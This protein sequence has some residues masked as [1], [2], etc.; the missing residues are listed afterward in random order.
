MGSAIERRRAASPALLFLALLGIHSWLLA[1]SGSEVGPLRS[2]ETRAVEE[3]A[4]DFL[5]YYARVL[6]LAKRHSA[7]P[8]SL[9]AALDSLP[10]THL[11]E[12]Q[13]EAWT[14]PF[15]DDPE[16][17]ADRLEE[18]ITALSARQ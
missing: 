3:I 13:W 7:N 1:C 11:S 9:R 14:K 5:D 18:V 2:R 17:L 4:G 6:L 15:R 16:K 8:D 12:E 10:G